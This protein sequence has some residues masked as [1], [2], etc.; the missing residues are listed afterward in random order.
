[1][2][3]NTHTETVDF[4][5]PRYQVEK[6]SG[7]SRSSIY[8]LISIGIFPRPVA[9]GSGGVRWKQSDITAWQ[10]SLTKTV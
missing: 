8:R 6:Q 1:M 5:L 7:L 4:L 3:Q 10:A 2:H 9:I